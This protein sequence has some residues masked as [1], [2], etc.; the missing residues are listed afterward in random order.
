MEMCNC[1]SN[2]RLKIHLQM[3]HPEISVVDLRKMLTPQR[4]SHGKIGIGSYWHKG[5]DSL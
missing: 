3:K 1:C 2:K 4:K 5:F